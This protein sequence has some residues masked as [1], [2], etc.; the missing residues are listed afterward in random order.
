[1]R[2]S[3]PARV[4]L[5]G[6][7]RG[8]SAVVPR[9]CVARMTRGVEDGPVHSLRYIDEVSPMA[10]SKFFRVAVE[11][12]TTDG[13]TMERSWISDIAA[14]YNPQTYGARIF[15]EHIRGV[16][17][18][19]PFKA[20][21]DVTAVKAEEITEGDLKGRLALFA[22]IEPTTDLV[23]LA[24]AKQKIYS[25]IE[26]NPKFA[27]SGRAYLVGL[28]VTD[29]PASLGT[30]M[31]TFAAQ[32]STNPLAGRKQS[33]ENLFTA[34]EPIEIE[35]EEE[36]E[37][38]GAA[39]LFAAIKER[40]AKLTGKT[41]VQDSQFAEFGDALGGMADA[42]EQLAT[43]TTTVTQQFGD[44]LG[45]LTRRL[46]AIEQAGQQTA[47]AFAALRTELEATPAYTARPPATGGSSTVQTDC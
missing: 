39:T 22:Q 9:Y 34:A 40:L 25:S 20:Y 13:R 28:G 12:A 41:K 8:T 46:D 17:P 43:R 1:M 29:S 47:A 6:L 18:D 31:L 45:A 38:G 42:L 14:T 4:R 44:Q 26:V 21:G 5:D 30:D 33:P 23:S 35:W 11:G 10:K 15:L 32:A 19:G 16:M 24:K 7:R 36:S 2:A 27:S 37:E 3:S